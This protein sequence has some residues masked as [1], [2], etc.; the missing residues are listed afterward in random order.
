MNWCG[1]RVVWSKELFGREEGKA[2]EWKLFHP[3]ERPARERN[4]IDTFLRTCFGQY[5][6]RRHFWVLAYTS[7]LG[8][9][10]AVRQNIG[11]RCYRIG[12]HC[13]GEQFWDFA[14]RFPVACGRDSE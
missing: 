2:T 13:S 14:C 4:I 9:L 12:S 3:E 7:K 8:E 6:L 11:G 1:Y 5:V 10:A